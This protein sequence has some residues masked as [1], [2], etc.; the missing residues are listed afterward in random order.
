MKK[1]DVRCTSSFSTG[2]VFLS[3]NPLGQSQEQFHV[4]I[5]E[6]GDIGGNRIQIVCWDRQNVI[7]LLIRNGEIG[8]R[9]KFLPSER[10]KFLELC[11]FFGEQVVWVGPRPKPHANGGGQHPNRNIGK[12]YDIAAIRPPEPR[13]TNIVVELYAGALLKV[14]VLEQ[15]F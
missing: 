13:S 5:I 11:G 1:L 4:S 8:Q 3:V 15:P 6:R 14:I 9:I 7:K 12:L 2:S 10:S